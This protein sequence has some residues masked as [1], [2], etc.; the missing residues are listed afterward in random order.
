M[1]TDRGTCVA[2]GITDEPW[3]LVCTFYVPFE[4]GIDL[5]S[6]IVARALALLAEQGR[7]L[8]AT[9]EP[10]DEP[11]P[12][13]HLADIAHVIGGERRIRTHTVLT[14]LATH[15]HC[16]V[17]EPYA[18]PRRCRCRCLACCPAAGG[19]GSLA[20]EGAPH[21]VGDTA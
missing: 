11:P 18:P 19:C 4:D 1:K 17:R 8:T 7:E 6:P 3:E 16:T 9:A 21:F 15:N 13:D 10:D 20:A 5:V 14:Q 12:V 2:V